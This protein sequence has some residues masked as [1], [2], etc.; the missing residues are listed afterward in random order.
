MKG[1]CV[2]GQWKLIGVRN[3]LKKTDRQK[4]TE[5]ISQAIP[6]LEHSA[7]ENFAVRIIRETDDRLEDNVREWMEHRP[8]SDIMIGKYCVGMIMAIRGDKDFL[9]ALETLSLYASNP[10]LGECQIWRVIR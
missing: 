3:M 9:S 1:K 8:I 4:L 10:E 5:A 6:G 7:C 2:N